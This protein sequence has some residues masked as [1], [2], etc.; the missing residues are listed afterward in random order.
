[1][2]LLPACS[3]RLAVRPALQLISER[4]KQRKS[5]SRGFRMPI[6]Q[7][8][9]PNMTVFESCLSA[10]DEPGQSGGMRVARSARTKPLKRRGRSVLFYC[11]VSPPGAVQAN[12]PA[13]TRL[14]CL[15]P[16]SVGS[17]KSTKGHVVF[18]LV[19]T[20]RRDYQQPDQSLFYRATYMQHACIAR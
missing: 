5:F 17:L 9:L 18:S 8:V 4:S 13:D 12:T 1:M 10:A 7:A 3:S 14:R 2:D 6:H 20:W 19:F 11:S 16:P 15:I